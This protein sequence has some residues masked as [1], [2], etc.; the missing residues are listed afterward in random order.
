MKLEIRNFLF[1]RWKKLDI[2]LWEYKVK[3][4][5]IFEVFNGGNLVMG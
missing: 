4:Y 5:V 3:F 1:N 2:R